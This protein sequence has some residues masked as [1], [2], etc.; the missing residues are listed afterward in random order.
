[1]WQIMYTCCAPYNLQIN[2]QE[3]SGALDHLEH[4]LKST[5]LHDTA[6]AVAQSKAEVLGKVTR[7]A[8]NVSNLVE[9]RRFFEQSSIDLLL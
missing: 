1:M 3:L 7:A 5:G 9:V 6:A 2:I 4:K 8:D